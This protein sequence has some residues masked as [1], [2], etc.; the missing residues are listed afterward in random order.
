MGTSFGQGSGGFD[1][2]GSMERVFSSS[3]FLSNLGTSSFLGSELESLC[4][5]YD[6]QQRGDAG[7][8]NFS[9][10]ASRTR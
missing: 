5:R 10:V 9:H 1:Q 6:L 3:D 8:S 4:R 2:F 7:A